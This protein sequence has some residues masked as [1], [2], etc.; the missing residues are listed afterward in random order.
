MAKVKNYITFSKAFNISPDILKKEG[1]IDPFL[2]VDT[3][4]FID[5]LLLSKSKNKIINTNAVKQFRKY[6]NNLN[7][8]LENATPDPK[9][10]FWKQ[11]SK[12]LSFKELPYTCLGYGAASTGGQSLSKE[13][14]K[15][16]L[17]TTKQIVDLGV[18]KPEI[19]AL[20][21]MLEEGVGPDTI[22]DLTTHTILE[23][24]AE[25]TENFSKKYLK[26]SD[27]MKL[28]INKKDFNVPK[29][30]FKSNNEP[31]ILVPRDIVKN[32]PIANDWSSVMVAAEKNRQLRAEVNNY[33]GDIWK[34]KSKKDKKELKEAV[35]QDK[36]S[37]ETF[38]K[39]INNAPNVPYEFD[40]DKDGL[41]NWFYQ[42]DSTTALSIKKPTV[43]SQDEL[44]AIV[45]KIISYFKKVVE[46]NGMSRLLYKDQYTPHSEKIAQK[47]FFMISKIICDQNN[48]DVS[49]ETDSGNGPVDF[50][51]SKGNA[52]VL[53][54]IKLSRNPKVKDGYTKQLEAYKQAECTNCGILLLIEVTGGNP[55]I[56]EELIKLRNKYRQ[57]LG[58]SE[59]EIVDGRWKQSASKR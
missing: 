24:L 47:I 5:P 36:E 25:I 7:I 39:M 57:Y 58:S 28:T 10:P 45:N 46:D 48:I 26:I 52:K 21:P 49:P 59:I 31:L 40:K 13:V 35:L 14:C 50:K 9:N 1:L 51:F 41:F 18:K 30:F 37:I 3:K 44:L 42:L 22:S 4:L 12:M 29:N 56:A 11:A 33:I 32:L 38:E 16:V 15:N 19:F 23:A 2:T 34:L 20:V 27:L 55:H 43:Y 53:V 8:L 6:F 54:E 17:E